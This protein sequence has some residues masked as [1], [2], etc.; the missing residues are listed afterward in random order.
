[1]QKKKELR[2]FEN[3]KG[4]KCETYCITVRRTF[5]EIVHAFFRITIKRDKRRILIQ[6]C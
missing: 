1:M 2:G 5:E 3:P 6:D 4:K